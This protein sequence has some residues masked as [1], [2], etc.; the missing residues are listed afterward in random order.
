[1]PESAESP[2]RQAGEPSGETWDG[3]IGDLERLLASL[4]WAGWELPESYS[5]EYDAEAGAFLFGELVRTGMAIGVQYQPAKGE[6]LLLPCDYDEDFYQL[7][8][9][10]SEVKISLGD[11][12]DH[13]AE[14]VADQAGELGLLDATRLAATAD[15][16]IST[17]ELV[18]DRVTEWIVEPA[19]SYRNLPIAEFTEQLTRDEKFF[20]RFEWLLNFLAKRVLPDAVPDAAA[21]GIA[22][23]CWRN[24][25]EVENWHLPSD[26][27]MA[28]VSIAATKAVQSYVDPEE[29]VDWQGIED[30]LTD[31][32]WQLADGRVISELFGE[33]WPEVEQSVR[34]QLRMWRHFEEDLIGPDAML[35]LLTIAGSTSYTRHWWGQGRWAAICRAIITDATSAGVPLPAPYDAEGAAALLRDLRDPEALSDD[36][37]GWMIDIPGTG[38]DGPCGLRFH[39]SARPVIREFSLYRLT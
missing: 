25:T 16:D 36:V 5:I 15:S 8:M 12:V 2:S 22:A 13:G 28:K 24:D 31:P 39:E 26:T 27:L 21:V 23:W 11:D 32:S 18:G 7:S 35:R 14:L 37:L 19:A 1:M 30:S 33:G 34:R 6:L 29:G 20:P 17:T 9:L 10:D 3:Y 38:V 4:T